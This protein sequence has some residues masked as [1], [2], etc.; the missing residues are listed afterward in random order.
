MLCPYPLNQGGLWWDTESNPNRGQWHCLR[1]RHNSSWII[2]C[3]PK[4]Q[5]GKL[6]K[7]HIHYLQQWETE[8]SDCGSGRAGEVQGDRTDHPEALYPDNFMGGFGHSWSLTD[9]VLLA[10]MSASEDDPLVEEALQ[11]AGR[12][13]PPLS[14]YMYEYSVSAFT[15][16]GERL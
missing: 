8:I 6:I 4:I 5:V 11:L 10:Q 14:E 1:R 13:H 15:G 2:W 3:V 9:S 12:M 7:F 16:C